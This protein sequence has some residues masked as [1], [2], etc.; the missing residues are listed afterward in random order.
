MSDLGW[1]LRRA[2]RLYGDRVAFCAQP[3]ASSPT[4]CRALELAPGARVGFLGAN[5]RAHAEAWLGVPAAG[6]VIVSLNYRLAPEELR[7]IAR[8]AELVDPHRRPGRLDLALA[9]LPRVDWE[10]LLVR[11]A[12]RAARPRARHA[13][14]DLLHR[15]HDRD[16]RRA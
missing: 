8:D 2:A 16:G 9:R 10:D 14:R 6:G 5:T 4:G 3:I 12:G 13:R 15:R 1:P 7:F 11:P